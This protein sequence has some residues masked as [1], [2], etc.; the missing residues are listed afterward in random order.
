MRRPSL[1]AKLISAYTLKK[2]FDFPEK[3]RTC[4]DL[5]SESVMTNL[6][7][8]EW[9]LVQKATDEVVEHT[10]EDK[11]PGKQLTLTEVDLLSGETGKRKKVAKTV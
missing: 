10:P 4:G 11:M 9:D 8:E 5:T 7:E 3:A 6:T 2:S 1:T